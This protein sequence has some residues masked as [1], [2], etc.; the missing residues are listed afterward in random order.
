VTFLS[1]SVVTG[2]SLPEKADRLALRQA[3]ERGAQAE[4]R[5]PS[6]SYLTLIHSIPGA[7]PGSRQLYVLQRSLDV[8]LAFLH[9][10]Q[11]GLVRN[12][13]AVVLAAIL[14]G[15]LLA[16][17]VVQPIRR[18]VRGA[19][20]MESG[21]YDYPLDVRSN[22]EIGYLT[23]RFRHM[24]GGQRAYVESLEEAARLKSE[25]ISIASHELRTPVT[26]I[27]SYS[28]LLSDGVLGAITPD[29]RKALASIEEGL[30]RIIRITED[31]T[32][33]AQ[34][35]SERAT[36][37]LEDH[38]VAAVLRNAVNEAVAEAPGRSVA[39][40]IEVGPDLGRARLD[41][42]RLAQAIGN[43][44]R[45]G[46]RFT[47]DGGS[48]HVRGRRQGE[49]L[50][51]EIQDTGVGISEAQRESLFHRSFVLRDPRHHHSSR[52]L[53][54][55]SS[56]LGLGLP[57][58]CGIVEAHGGTITAESRVGEGST[59]TISLPVEFSAAGKPRSWQATP[60]LKSAA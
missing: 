13:L 43:L 37:H 25:F 42:P 16:H 52:T 21:N 20:E 15:L 11:G 41:G 14:I 8:E 53:E 60:I 49:D 28:E 17:E 44:I 39:V 51:I 4:V 34:I 32:F 10:L 45:N 1:G 35:D 54:F 36:L 55:N 30:R 58:A 19:E 48:V 46:I 26:I 29:Q 18:L 27:Q 22:D 50:V 47:P 5:F 40:G 59:F 38:E 2:S 23:E 7:A 57:I 6:G 33:L 9:G 56:G 24:R 12:G 31:A 3:V